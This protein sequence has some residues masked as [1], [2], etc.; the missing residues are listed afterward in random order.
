MTPV[1]SPKGR[2]LLLLRGY[3]DAEKGIQLCPAEAHS[4]LSWLSESSCA[5]E[6]PFIRLTAAVYA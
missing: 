2:P 1:P 6:S 5:R 3:W 4:A